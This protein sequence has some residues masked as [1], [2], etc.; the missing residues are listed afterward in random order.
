[1]GWISWRILQKSKNCVKILDIKFHIWLLHYSERTCLAERVREGTH[2]Y[3]C[4][5]LGYSHLAPKPLDCTAPSVWGG[6]NYCNGYCRLTY[7]HGNPTTWPRWGWYHPLCLTVVWRCYNSARQNI[8][9]C[10]LHKW[11]SVTVVWE[12]ACS[13]QEREG[14]RALQKKQLYV[15]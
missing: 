11:S 9:V 13:N 6:R 3:T 10:Y 14:P 4:L 2:S 8:K 5:H 12:V 1:M 7:L 15:I